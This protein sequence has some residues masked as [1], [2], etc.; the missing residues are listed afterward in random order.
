MSVI[1]AAIFLAAQAQTDPNRLPIGQNGEDTVPL[2]Q[3]YDLDHQ[4]RATIQDIVNAAK[5]KKFVFLGENHATTDHQQM[6]AEVIAALIGSGRHVV[7]GL[8]MYQRP[9]QTWL[10]QWSGGSITESDFL[11]KSDW[12]GQWGY[13]FAFYRPV[14]QVVRDNA[15]P[16]IGLNVP[17]DWVRSVGKQGFAG[18]SNEA[19][20]T[21]PAHMDLGNKDHRAMWNAMIG[22]GAHPMTGPSIENMYAAQVLWDESMADTA[23]K[24]LD[25]APRDSKAVF[26]VIAGSGHVM[27]KQGINWRIAK[28]SASDGVTVVMVQSDGPATVARGLGDFV[29]VTPEQKKPNP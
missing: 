28:R 14:F 5:N 7:V 4:K 18:L 20:S 26:V 24:Y 15:V 27:Y 21:L 9:K 17:R 19:S 25:K 12:K 11:D 23:I 8:E 3:I 10:D 6:E 2:G 16:L 13:D 22:G 1:G 29:Y